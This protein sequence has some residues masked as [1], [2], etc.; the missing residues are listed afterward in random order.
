LQQTT[1]QHSSA[2]RISRVQEDIHNLQYTEETSIRPKF[3]VIFESTRQ[4][5]QT[6]GPSMKPIQ[7]TVTFHRRLCRR[8]HA[9]KLT[10]FAT[11][12]ASVVA[13]VT[14]PDG[15]QTAPGLLFCYTNSHFSIDVG[16]ECCLGVCSAANRCALEQERYISIDDLGRLDSSLGC[17]QEL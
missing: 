14:G 9:A 1:M 8:P 12:A 11:N 7:H 5:C 10:H 13:L 2:S 3:S 16:S 17:K 6:A 15:A 4:L